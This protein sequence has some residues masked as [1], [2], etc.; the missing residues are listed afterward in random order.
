M[1]CINQIRGGLLEEVVLLLLDRSGYRR[2][3]VGEEGTRNGRAG[4]EVE[5]RGSHHQIDALV[6]PVHSHAFIYYPIRLMVEAKCETNPVGL[7]GI[8]RHCERDARGG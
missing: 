3:R 7:I 2:V 1:A 4:L 8:P 5:G 6:S